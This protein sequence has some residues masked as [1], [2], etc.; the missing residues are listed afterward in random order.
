MK[1]EVLEQEQSHQ[2]EPRLSIP[3]N[4]VPQDSMEIYSNTFPDIEHDPDCAYLAPTGG[5]NQQLPDDQRSSAAESFDTVIRLDGNN[6]EGSK[7]NEDIADMLA[8]GDA[9]KLN[10]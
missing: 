9:P 1:K 10:G 7:D 4:P 3:F 8:G 2:C 6:E 5:G